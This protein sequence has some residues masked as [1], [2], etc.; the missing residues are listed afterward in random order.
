[1]V[2]RVL[3]H[4][5]F[6]KTG[7]STAERTLFDNRAALSGDFDIV[8]RKTWPEVSAAAKR[9]SVDRGPKALAAFGAALAARLAEGMPSGRRGLCISNV[10]LCG[11]MPGHPGVSDYSAVP[12]LMGETGRRMIERFGA[13][14][15]LRF[16]A[17][18]RA[19][20]PWLRSLYWQNLKV[21]RLTLDFGDFAGRY[22]RAADFA[23]VLT[24]IEAETGGRPLIRAR[25]ED[26]A[27]DRL[28]PAA[29]VLAAM[30]LPEPVARTLTA[31]RAL[32]VA[33][34]EAVQR[35]VLKMNRSDLPDA[36]LADAKAAAIALLTGR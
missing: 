19:P 26:S 4:F 12:P 31:H 30:G 35:A 34:D 5:G 22:G 27:C 18:I 9:A 7:S 15:D 6:H 1:M 14:V 32:K 20:E 3:V 13:D 28:G 36:A 23:P 11:A 2:G 29:P 8:G 24:A 33:P 21:N 17:T 16:L 25:L 10:D